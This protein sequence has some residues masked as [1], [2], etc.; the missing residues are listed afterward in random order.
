MHLIRYV[1]TYNHL[2]CVSLDLEFDKETGALKKTKLVTE[3]DLI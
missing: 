3:T 1:S 2:H